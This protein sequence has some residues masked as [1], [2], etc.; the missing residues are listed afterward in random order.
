MPTSPDGLLTKARKDSSTLI[1]VVYPAPD[2]TLLFSGRKDPIVIVVQH[3][4]LVMER[5]CQLLAIYELRW[6]RQFSSTFLSTEVVPSRV[7]FCNC[8]TLMLNPI[9]CMKFS[10]RWLT[11]PNAPTTIG[12]TSTFFT[13]HRCFTSNTSISRKLVLFIWSLGC[14]TGCSQGQVNFWHFLKIPA[15]P[16]RDTFCRP[17]DIKFQQAPRQ[18]SSHFSQSAHNCRDS[19]RSCLPYR[20]YFSSKLLVFVCLFFLFSATRQSLKTVMSIIQTFFPD[21]ANTMR[22]GSWC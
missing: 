1:K 12:I 5:R 17:S 8:S 2:T 9:L 15:V 4:W 7:V 6:Q 10:T 3:L 22:S 11:A 13:K 14:R 16:S 19:V 20:S 18:F 21:F